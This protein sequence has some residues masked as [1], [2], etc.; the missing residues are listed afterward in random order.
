M[1]KQSNPFDRFDENHINKVWEILGSKFG[2]NVKEW[3]MRFREYQLRHHRKSMDV[4]AFLIFGEKVLN[5]L[6][7]QILQRREGFPT[8]QRMVRFVI[9]GKADES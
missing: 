5:P 9:T 6:L 7:N 3:R 2:F 4:D 8:F 1:S